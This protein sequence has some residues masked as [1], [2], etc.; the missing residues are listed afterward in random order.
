M[1]RHAHTLLAFVLAWFCAAC[2]APRHFGNF[3]PH[4]SASQQRSLAR[5]AADLMQRMY[6]PATTT[7]ILD[8]THDAFGDELCT[9]L[10]HLGFAIADSGA[11]LSARTARVRYVVDEV[12][13]SFFRTTLTLHRASD[14]APLAVMTRAYL[15]T[16]NAASPAGAWTRQTP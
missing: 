7:L 8:D 1:T 3:L 9:R 5:D 13:T 11:P 15:G 10:R 14:L 2:A 12:D 6:S 16:K 4:A